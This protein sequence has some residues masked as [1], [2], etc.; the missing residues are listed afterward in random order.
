MVAPT[1]LKEAPPRSITL[2]DREHIASSQYVELIDHLRECGYGFNDKKSLGITSSVSGEGVTTIACNLALHLA[3]FTD[4]RVILVDANYSSPR[5]HQIFGIGS[6]PGLAD[7]FA[8]TAMESECIHD[9]ANNNSGT[10]PRGLR[11]E[12]RRERARIGARRHARARPDPRLRDEAA[13]LDRLLQRRALDDRRRVPRLVDGRAGAVGGALGVRMSRDGVSSDNSAFGPSST[14]QKWDPEAHVRP[15]E[16]HFGQ[17][18]PGAS[19][20]ELPVH[21]AS[22]AA[23]AVKEPPAHLEGAAL[24][25]RPPRLFGT[26]SSPAW[27]AASSADSCGRHASAMRA[28]RRSAPTPQVIYRQHGFTTYT[29]PS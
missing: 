5:L 7:L 23:E 14:F 16:G 25:R 18:G 1:S 28:A 15:M 11:V 6:K 2:R 19:V 29:K 26:G 13:R 12:E 10:L 8:E 22:A 20:E 24:P 3:F 4:C 17:Y 27:A 9:L 21:N